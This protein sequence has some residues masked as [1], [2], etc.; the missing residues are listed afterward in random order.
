MKQ[1]TMAR[2]PQT[3]NTPAPISPSP[4]PKTESTSTSA[5]KRRRLDKAEGVA[6]PVIRA[7]MISL[8]ISDQGRIQV[9]FFDTEPL[10]R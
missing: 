9:A 2:M 6:A 5:E 4:A 1:H 3:I 7:N 10:E 8:G